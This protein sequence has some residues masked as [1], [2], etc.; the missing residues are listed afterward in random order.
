LGAIRAAVTVV[1]AW[2]DTYPLKER[3]DPFFHQQYAAV[4]HIPYVG[5]GQ[6]A[7]FVML[8]QPAKFQ[9]ALEHFLNN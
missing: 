6:S 8:D 5:I 2:N 9:E 3:A 7:H 4:Q 1:Y